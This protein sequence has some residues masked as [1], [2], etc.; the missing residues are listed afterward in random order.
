MK[1]LLTFAVLA[2]AAVP[3]H[4]AEEAPVTLSPFAGNVGNALWTLIIFVIVVVVLG[5]FA[6]GPLLSL[7]QQREDFIHKSLSDAKRD[8]DEAE[9]RLRDYAAKLQ[10]AQAEA[11]GIVEEARRDA[12]RLR[13]ELRERAKAE[14]DTILKNAERQIELQTTRA[15]QQIRREAVDLS[16]TIASKLLQRNITKEDN[17]KLIDD[18]LRQIESSSRSH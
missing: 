16:V 2:L 1:K 8:R 18:A 6:W 17:E 10:S 9:A 14:A 11:V 4:A 15:L 12:E 7:L 3:L 5:K 13:G